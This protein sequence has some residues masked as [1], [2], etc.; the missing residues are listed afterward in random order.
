MLPCGET[1]TLSGSL[2]RHPPLSSEASD[3]P[4][5]ATPSSIIRYNKRLTVGQVHA[6]VDKPLRHYVNSGIMCLVGSTIIGLT[7]YKRLHYA[8]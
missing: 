3:L 5:I 7:L 4:Y 1:L 2:N 8:A 6:V